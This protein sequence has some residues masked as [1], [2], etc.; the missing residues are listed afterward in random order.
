MADVIEAK[1]LIIDGVTYKLV[2]EDVPS[3]AKKSK[4][5]DTLQNPGE[6]ADSAVTG[7]KISKMERRPFID[8]DED[9]RLS[10]F[11]DDDKED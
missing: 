11:C 3:W 8:Y 10:F 6:P 1:T 7:Q 9:G 4:P 2:D 5:D